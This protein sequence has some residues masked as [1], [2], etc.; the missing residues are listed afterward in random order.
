MFCAGFWASPV[1]EG[2]PP[3]RE[4]PG[5]SPSTA[6]PGLP[7][8]RRRQWR[9]RRLAMALFVRPPVVWTGP[10]GSRGP[11]ALPGLSDAPNGS[12]SMNDMVSHPPNTK[13]PSLKTYGSAPSGDIGVWMARTFT[14]GGC[15]LPATKFIQLSAC[16]SCTPLK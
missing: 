1:P 14:Y 6:R 8:P 3:V 5:Q 11:S 10:A 16:H 4:V 7:R 13:A 9:W 2:S 15:E 12:R